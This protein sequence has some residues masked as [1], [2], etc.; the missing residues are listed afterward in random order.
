MTAACLSS[1]LLGSFMCILI[2]LCRFFGLDPDNIAPPVASCLGDL[3]TLLL[4]GL[5]SSF[6]IHLEH[7]PVPFFIA[8]LVILIALSCL[9]STRKNPHVRKLVGQGWT[10]LFGAM[11]ISSGTGIV[12]DLFVS[13]YEG[14]ALLAVVISGL[15]GSVGSIFVSRLSTKLHKEQVEVALSAGIRSTPRVTQEEEED[16][17]SDSPRPEENTHLNHP[18]KESSPKPTL[19]M[20]TLLITTVPIEFIFLSLLRLLGWLHLPLL[21]VGFS[22]IFF[23]CAVTISLFI[24]RWL[25]YLLWKRKLDPDIY[26]LP[27][28]SA[29]M[30]LIG[31]GLLVLCFEVVSL[32]GVRPRG[33]PKG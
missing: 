6:L 20:L 7:T 32:L 9:V 11:I 1:L 23:C 28:H 15:P 33:K 21:F 2:V 30:D 8:L 13:R 27:I 29:L 22:L 12:L 17:D 16:P 26:A 10:P 24:A 14:F 18:R 5:I 31:Q 4:M 25:T 19:V 3:V